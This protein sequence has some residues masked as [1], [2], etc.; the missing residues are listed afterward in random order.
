MNIWLNLILHYLN[1]YNYMFRIA[2]L[3]NIS[4]LLAHLSNAQTKYWI[5]FK[6]KDTSGYELSQS[7]SQETIQKRKLLEI[8][9][10]QV[11]DVP[12]NHKYLR[13]I[14]S[15]GI[16][17]LHKSKWLNSVS[18]YLNSEQLAQLKDKFF[19]QEIVPINSKVRITSCNEEVNPT[20]V[21][22]ALAQMQSHFFSDQNLTGKGINIGVID[23]GFFRAHLEKNLEHLFKEFRI[24]AQRDFQNPERKDIITKSETNGDGHGKSVLEK[25]CGY[26]ADLR[27][28][29]GMAVNANFYI[30]RTENGNKEN[31]GEEDKWIEAVEWM[32]SLGVRLISTSLGYSTKM[33]DPLDN[34]K[35]EEMNGSTTKISKAAQLAV[36]NKGIFLVVSAG[37]EG[38]SAWKIISS[39]ADTR[40]ALSVGATREYTLDRIGYSSIGPEFLPY[41]KPEVSCFSPNGT[42]FSA[43]AVTGFVACLMQKKPSIKNTDLKKVI[44]QSAHLYPYGNNFI[45]YGVPQADRALVLLENPTQTF[46]NTI[47]KKVRGKKIK[48]KLPENTPNHG[49]IFHKKNE[50]IVVK[51]QEVNIIKRKLKLRRQ[52]NVTHTTLSV[53][54]IVVEFIWK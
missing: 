23:A 25:I 51:Q 53:G 6:D 11:S 20:S 50:T 2:F 39:P 40:G 34:Y 10:Y 5:T 45:G 47:I 30:A 44:E 7:I 17:I 52:T 46:K 13:E 43:P 41:L 49:I 14:S 12:L 48:F 32:D 31:R 29:Y 28:Q 1:K 26:D 54:S 3:L 18:A 35:L 24:L 33:D 9:L 15:I 27:V 8:P 42:S 38:A 22:T 21:H 36:D 19:V 4:V 37:N 16:N